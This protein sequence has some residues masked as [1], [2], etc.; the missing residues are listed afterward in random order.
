MAYANEEKIKQKIV[1]SYRRGVCDPNGGTIP[2]SKRGMAGKGSHFSPNLIPNEQYRKN[3][4]QID[5][6]M[7]D[8]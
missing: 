1:E 3:Y 8:N 6:K 5:W 2:K 4:D 7:L